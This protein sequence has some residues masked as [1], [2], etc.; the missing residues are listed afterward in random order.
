MN[1]PKCPQCA[2][3]DGEVFLLDR[4]TSFRATDHWWN[5][6]VGH[7]QAYAA[8]NFP[9]QIMT[10]YPAFFERSADDVE[11]AIILLHE[12]QHLRGRGSRERWRRC[13][14][15]R[16]VSAGRRRTPVTRGCG[17][18]RGSG[19]TRSCRGSSRAVST[20]RPTATRNAGNSAEGAPDRLRTAW[21][22]YGLCSGLVTGLGTYNSAHPTRP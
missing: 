2:L 7:G 10:L 6:H 16:R 3:V 12:A 13:G 15:K 1:S 20:P 17:R 14:A 4:M 8:T 18:T 22:S 11:R 9:F 19:H 21:Y 5:E